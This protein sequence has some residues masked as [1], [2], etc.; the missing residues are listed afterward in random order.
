MKFATDPTLHPE[1]GCAGVRRVAVAWMTCHRLYVY[2]THANEVCCVVLIVV[3]WQ[4]HSGNDPATQL[5]P[6]GGTTA[7]WKTEEDASKASLAAGSTWGS[8]MSGAGGNGNPAAPAV[9]SHS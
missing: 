8:G 5:V 9:V 2:S 3:L 1:A 4:E 6:S 7:G